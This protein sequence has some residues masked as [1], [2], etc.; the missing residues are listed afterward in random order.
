MTRG[1]AQLRLA[2]EVDSD[3]ISGWVSNGSGIS[4]PFHGWIELTAVI[5]AAR[6]ADPCLGELGETPA[7]RL[8]SIPGAKASEL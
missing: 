8:G 4:K 7:E 3:P 1:T 2:I 6:V 5:E